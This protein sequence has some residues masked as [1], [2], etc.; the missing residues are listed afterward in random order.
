MRGR[1]F[2]DQLFH[3]EDCL[4]SVLLGVIPQKVRFGQ[5]T[6]KRS[7]QHP[8]VDLAEIDQIST[9][10]G[11]DFL[12]R[13]V[14]VEKLYLSSCHQLLSLLQGPHLFSEGFWMSDKQE[15]KIVV[16]A[17]EDKAVLDWS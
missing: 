15:I 16:G 12:Y 11:K 10:G 7:A 5:K 3:T 9:G 6:V 8:H 4:V 1:H 14:V 2:S 13:V 17:V